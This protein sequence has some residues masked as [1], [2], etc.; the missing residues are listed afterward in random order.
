MVKFIDVNI[1]REVCV[2]SL[3]YYKFYLN[4]ILTSSIIAGK[5]Y[6]IRSFLCML[7]KYY[8]KDIDLNKSIVIKASFYLRQSQCIYYVSCIYVCVCECEINYLSKFSFVF[9]ILEKQMYIFFSFKD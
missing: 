1:F 4:N 2:L 6:E 3:H 7:S 8:A 9:R 5:S